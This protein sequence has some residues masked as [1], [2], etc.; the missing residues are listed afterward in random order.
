MVVVCLEGSKRGSHGGGGV[1]GEW[2]GVISLLAFKSQPRFIKLGCMRSP[3]HDSS[4][5]L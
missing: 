3:R 5:K 4:V 1:R 2:G